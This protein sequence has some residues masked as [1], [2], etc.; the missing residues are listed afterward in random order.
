MEDLEKE[1]GHIALFHYNEVAGDAVGVV[2]RP[3]A[4]MPR[5]AR[6]NDLA[7][8]CPVTT[9]GGG[10]D[11]NKWKLELTVLN[12]A[13]LLGRMTALGKGLVARVQLSSLDE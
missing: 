7:H 6:I 11:G 4:F 1:F 9:G 5:T 8:T 10:G 2:W 3:E 12:V 13:E